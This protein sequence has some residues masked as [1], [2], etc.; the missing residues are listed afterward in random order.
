MDGSLFQLKGDK[1]MF[2]NDCIPI[3]SLQKGVEWKVD[4]ANSIFLVQYQDNLT[5]RSKDVTVS[6]QMATVLLQERELM[7]LFSVINAL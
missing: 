5:N 3:L 6:A 4:L 1:G 2:I 7:N